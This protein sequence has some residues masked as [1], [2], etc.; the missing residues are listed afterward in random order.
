MFLVRPPAYPSNPK[1]VMN[2]QRK[3]L[4]EIGCNVYPCFFF[5]AQTVSKKPYWPLLLFAAVSLNKVRN[6][7]TINGTFSAQIICHARAHTILQNMLVFFK[8]S[9][10]PGKISGGWLRAAAFLSTGQE[11]DMQLAI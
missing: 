3:F 4:E 2:V 11:S 6:K 5:A 8:I 7:R 9:Q 1:Y 10:R